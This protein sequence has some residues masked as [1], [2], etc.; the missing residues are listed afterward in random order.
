ML[1]VYWIAQDGEY[2]VEPD[3]APYQA[4]D[5]LKEMLGSDAP[6]VCVHLIR[7]RMP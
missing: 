5:A 6:D 7:Y 3:S 1:C 4:P 2:S